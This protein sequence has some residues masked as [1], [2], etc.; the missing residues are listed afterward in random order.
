[1]RLRGQ[2]LGPNERAKKVTLLGTIGLV[3]LWWTLAIA[4]QMSWATG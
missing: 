1:M 2:H 4:G 3:I